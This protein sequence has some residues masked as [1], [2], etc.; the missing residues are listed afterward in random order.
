LLK[1]IRFTIAVLILLVAVL[2]VYQNVLI[3]RDSGSVPNAQFPSRI[4][5]WVSQEVDYDPVVLSVLSPD[6]IIYKSY[7]DGS[8]NPPVTLFMAYYNTLEKAEMSHSPIV[9][10]TGQGW[11][12]EE[13]S[14]KEVKVDGAGD[15]KI[16]VNEMLQKKLNVT[17]VTLYW[18][19]SANRAFANRAFQKFF[20]LLDRLLGRPD[21]NAFV[22]L[23]AVVPAGRTVEETSSNMLA[24][25]KVLYPSLNG[26]FQ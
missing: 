19:Q 18:Y 25:L 7:S 13:V 16:R 20:L 8:A 22:R 23:T 24:F 1:N 15:P 4:G 6:T 12:I 17:L 5:K 26:F 11:D 14:E 2:V 9:C 10:F 3:A 21:R